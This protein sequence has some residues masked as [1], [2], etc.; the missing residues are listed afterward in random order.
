MQ[1][2]GVKIVEFR[3]KIMTLHLPDASYIG[4]SSYS[5]CFCFLVNSDVWTQHWAAQTPNQPNPG[6][7]ASRSSCVPER[8]VM[9]E[10]AWIT[11]AGLGCQGS[12][13]FIP[14]R[15]D[16]PWEEVKRTQYT[17]RPICSLCMP[18]QAW[19][20]K[21]SIL[22]QYTQMHTHRHTHAEP[23]KHTHKWCS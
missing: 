15:G 2:A 6:H 20:L 7:Q 19:G 8:K 14:S 17:L 12:P 18:V 4:H 5:I 1:R 16:L 13:W 23:R 9:M 22:S 21:P 3:S 11:P 10:A